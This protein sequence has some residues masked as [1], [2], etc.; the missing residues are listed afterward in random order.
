MKEDKYSHILLPGLFIILLV[1][2]LYFLFSSMFNNNYICDEYISKMENLL[3]E[4][5][6]LDSNQLETIKKKVDE[7]TKMGQEMYIEDYEFSK[8]QRK[9]IVEIQNDVQ[10]FI[11]DKLKGLDF[12]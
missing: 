9:R 7:L 3:S 8:E 1:T 4:I 10:S 2:P 5:K 11:E 12:N 6:H